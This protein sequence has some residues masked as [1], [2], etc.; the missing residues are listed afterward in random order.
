MPDTAAQDIDPTLQPIVDEI[1]TGQTDPAEMSAETLAELCDALNRAYRA[2]CPVVTD[3]QYD[4]LFVRPLR[5][6]APDHPFLSAVEPEADAFDG[7]TVRHAA[8][9]LSTDKAYTENE[10]SAFFR[11]VEKSAA[12]I[13]LDPAAITFRATCKLDGIAGHDDGTRLVTRGDGLAGTDISHVIDAG[14]T[15]VGGRGLGPGELVIDQCYFEDVLRVEFPGLKHPRNYVAGFAGAKEIK[16]HHRSAAEAGALR[17]V[18]Y[19]TLPSWTGGA[20]AFLADWRLVYQNLRAESE[21][22]TDGIV[23]EVLGPAGLKDALGATSHHHRWQVAIKQKGEMAETTVERIRLQTGR[24]GRITPVL[25]I[26][27]VPLEGA[28]ISNVTAH[29]V[30]TLARQGLGVGAKVRISRAGGVIP[31]LEDVVTAAD[32]PLKVSACPSCESPAE[33]EGEYMVCP[34][35]AECPAQV[36]NRLKHWFA[37]LGNA[38]LFG[39]ATIRRLVAAGCTTIAD[40]YSLAEEDFAALGFGPGQSR[41]LADQLDRSRREPIPDWRFLAA[42]GIRHLGRGDS[43]KL[44]SVYPLDDV[45]GLTADQIEAVPGFGPITSPQIA[46]SLNRLAHL[47]EH[48]LGLGFSLEETPRG[49]N[50]GPLDGLSVVFTGKM[51]H[52]T[53]EAMSEQARALGATVQSSVTS[54]TDILVAGEKA[55]SKLKKAESL[56]SGTAT[57]VVKILDE[58]AW[59]ALVASPG[60]ANDAA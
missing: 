23:L 17:F 54:K 37:T 26:S 28:T 27:P 11:R 57:P 51:M 47:I 9:M 14:F 59:L 6:I 60:A 38:D 55:G 49:G 4:E 50:S 5:R 58:D 19:S 43:R 42:F 2:G 15:M 41:N 45:S 29:T 39:P 13:G 8:P 30:A 24:T 48:M 52:G 16:T 1:V 20:D 53:R 40:I 31:T 7:P 10:I 33:I 56:N 22:L 32:A 36:E 34:N 46:A 18:P 35:T 3:P 21:Y 12:S 25:E 44:L